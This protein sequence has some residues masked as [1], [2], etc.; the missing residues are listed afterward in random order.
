MTVAFIQA[1]GRIQSNPNTDQLN[2]LTNFTNLPHT[3]VK[4]LVGRTE[5]ERTTAHP[6]YTSTHTLTVKELL[7]ES[8]TIYITKC[9]GH[10]VRIC[11][12]IC[13]LFLRS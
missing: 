12:I 4:I 9:K 10:T 6:I 1:L 13:T 2:E 3:S 5:E 8:Q 7:T 11:A